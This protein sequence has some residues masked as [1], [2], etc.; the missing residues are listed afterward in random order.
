MNSPLFEPVT[1]G[2]M[3]VQNRIV[4]PAIATNFGD[5]NGFVTSHSIN[6]Y[7]KC[8][9]GSPGLII[10][11]VASIAN[12]GKGFAN[13]LGV[14]KDDFIPQ[15]RQLSDAIKHA[16]PVKSVVQLHHAGRRAS[17]KVNHGAQ[18][19]A[20]SAIA[21]FSGEMP[22]ELTTE[23]IEQ[24][25]EAFSEG[26][27]ISKDSG[28]DGVQIH[29]AHGYLIQ[30]FLS[31]LSNKRRDQY[32]G[33][34][35]SRARFALRILKRIREKVGQQYP[36]FA[37]IC[38]SEF[39]KGGITLKD[40]Q[41]FASVL[42]ETGISA[43][44]VSAGYKASS[45]EGF[46]NSIVAVA[47][48]PMAQPR[49]YFVHLAEGVKEVVKVPV[50]AVGRL[51]NPGLAEKV[52]VERKADLIA[53]G[54][55]FLADP[56]FPHKLAKQQY[57]N[58]R[59][60]IA[61][62][63]CAETLSG[64]TPVKC[65]VNPNLGREEYF[66]ISPSIKSKKVLVVGGGPGG[67]EAARVAA[68]RGHKVT[69][70]ERKPYLG[71]NLIAASAVS[72]K[73]EI[74]RLTDYLSNQVHEAGV[75]IRLNFTFDANKLS[76]LAPNAVILATGASAN[77]P[78]IPGIEGENVIDVIDVL[79]GKTQTGSRVIVVGAGLI[80]CEAAVF[81]VEKGK[82]VVLVT[83]RDSDFS[84]TGG[85]APDMEFILRRWFLSDLWPTLPIE[86]IANSTFKEVKDNGLMVQKRGGE[87]S[88]IE[89]DSVVFATGMNSENALYNKLQGK[90]VE[91]YKVGDCA[92]PR[93]IIDAIHEAAQFT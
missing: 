49:G 79:E 4:M 90:V 48:L 39:F 7:S 25:I 34:F 21:C 66:E 45:E 64:A 73:T 10:I 17:S 81:L 35:D 55:G 74:R 1:I 37:K 89:G 67:M 40:S 56:L 42:E 28:F 44:E 71:G 70:V 24:L 68:L 80:G 50:I 26:A 22:H 41:K 91:L 23:E 13:Q 15:L 86:V 36:V 53:I 57:E 87:T 14:Y 18:P 16:G 29:C 12:T 92:Q 20:P 5:G 63:S 11:E 72:F 88:L 65:A 62:N 27:R 85:L 38:G 46:F 43:I 54:R 32:G 61:C 33:D 78:S 82:E 2:T 47:N 93:K 52:I 75:E 77:K 84:L 60:C 31:P 59:P 3:E 83:R 51:D 9:S 30:Q 19:V 6:H 76:S 58:I 69:L 8:A